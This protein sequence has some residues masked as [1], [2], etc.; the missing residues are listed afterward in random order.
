MWIFSTSLC[1]ATWLVFI[2]VFANTKVIYCQDFFNFNV[3]TPTVSLSLGSH[4]V[5][6]GFHF[7]FSLQIPYTIFTLQNST[8]YYFKAPGNKQK[9]FESRF[10]AGVNLGQTPQKDSL[11]V[12]F[13]N[14]PWHFKNQVGYAYVYYWDQFRTSQAS[15]IFRLKVN[16]FH[17]QI[18]ND[19]FA[20]QDEDRYRTGAFYIGFKIKENWFYIKN[21]GYTGNPYPTGY[22]KIEDSDFQ[23]KYGYMDMNRAPHGDRSLGVISLGWASKSIKN[24]QLAFEA[25]IDAEQI[26]NLFQ[27]VLIHDS[28]WLKNPHIPMLDTEN[29]P[30]IYSPE[31]SIRKPKLYLQLFLNDYFL[32]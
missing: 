21:L 12:N 7:D 26:R 6:L 32:Y 11:R 24:Y 29:K 28:R 4:E 22:Q 10:E 20:F 25:G 3:P 23:S 8:R 1:K 2:I 16:S 17:Y 5:S 18:E 15:G 30:Y 9:G 19:Y 14:S 13:G 27:N 31:Q